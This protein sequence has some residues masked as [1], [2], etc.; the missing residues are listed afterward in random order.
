MRG[1][2]ILSRSFMGV[3]GLSET[4][5]RFEYSKVFLFKL[6]AEGEFHCNE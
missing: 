1:S 3:K 2:E 5:C 6:R 4:V